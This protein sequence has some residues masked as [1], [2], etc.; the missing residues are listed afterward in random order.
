MSRRSGAD[1]MTRSASRT[2]SSSRDEY[3]ILAM[4]ARVESSDAPFFHLLLVS[5][6]EAGE[7]VPGLLKESRR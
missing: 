2:A 7:P 6:R 1:S 5:G 3:L 4:A